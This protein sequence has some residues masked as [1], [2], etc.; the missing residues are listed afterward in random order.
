MLSTYQLEGASESDE[1]IRWKM[2]YLDRITYVALLGTK[3]LAAARLSSA[4]SEDRSP[5]GADIIRLSLKSLL[6]RRIG[7][8]LCI[9]KHKHHL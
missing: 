7:W 9:L 8:G 1:I 2:F 5:Q 3:I 6:A 4:R